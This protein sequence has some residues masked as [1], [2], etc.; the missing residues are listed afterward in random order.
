MNSCF[1]IHFNKGNV[2]DTQ[3]TSW[4][5]KFKFAGNGS[6]LRSATLICAHIL[7]FFMTL[8][9]IFTTTVLSYTPSSKI[10]SMT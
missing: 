4:L 2:Q 5:S 9:H 6:Y 3:D 8:I 10:I 1:G 7:E